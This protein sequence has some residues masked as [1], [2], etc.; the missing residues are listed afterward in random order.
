MS[1]DSTFHSGSEEEPWVCYRFQKPSSNRVQAIVGAPLDLTAYG[2]YRV[3]GPFLPIQAGY[4]RHRFRS[5][6]NAL[7]QRTGPISFRTAP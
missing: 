4:L 5:L 3:E 6:P 1:S 7:T 2:V